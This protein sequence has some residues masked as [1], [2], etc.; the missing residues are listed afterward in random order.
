MR[1]NLLLIIK[2]HW[3]VNQVSY[4]W[5]FG[6][7][8]S[9]FVIH[10]VCG[11]EANEWFVLSSAEQMAR[12]SP[13]FPLAQGGCSYGWQENYRR[14]CL[15]HQTVC[16]EKMRPSAMACIK[17]PIIALSAGAGWMYL[18]A[19]SQWWPDKPQSLNASWLN[20]STRNA[21]LRACSKRGCLPHIGRTKGGLNS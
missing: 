1:D 16:N 8:F 15:C 20:T 6:F 9:W 19:S 4:F 14:H 21:W 10:G 3:F 12:I 17:R 11:G 5:S 13:C 18:I 7:L 2:I